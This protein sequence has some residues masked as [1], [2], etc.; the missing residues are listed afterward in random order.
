MNEIEYAEINVLREQVKTLQS[1]VKAIVTLIDIVLRPQDGY[2]PQS[3]ETID[4]VIS[5][6]VK[7]VERKD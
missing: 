2:T 3:M 1:Q 6:L 7:S 5:N 4:V